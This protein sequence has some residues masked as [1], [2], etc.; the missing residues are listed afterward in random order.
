MYNRYTER[1]SDYRK[2]RRDGTFLTVCFSIRQRRYTL[3]SPAGTELDILHRSIDKVSSLRDF[4]SCP[5]HIRMLK[6]TVNKV[7]YLREILLRFIHFSFL[8]IS[9]DI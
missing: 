9:I 4:A 2:S 6:H 5:C 1:F 7:S 8:N 3:S